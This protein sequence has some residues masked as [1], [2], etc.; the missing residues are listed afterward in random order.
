MNTAAKT[1]VAC[2][3]KAKS[4][5]VTREFNAPLADVWRAFTEKEILDQWWGPAPWRAETK[6][7]N[8]TVGGYWLYAMVGPASERHWG[9]MTFKAIEHLKH[10]DVE[11]SFC[12]EHGTL[13]QSLPV[14]NAR[15]AFIK[16]PF[17][18]RVELRTVYAT[19][20]DVQKIVD[21]GFEQGISVCLDQLSELLDNHKI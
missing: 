9:R 21:M 17:G 20:A 10:Y 8:F 14:S 15:H 12:D 4:I 3:I 1:L 16:T 7:M 13:N 18:T 2:D 5:F 11:D 6:S 19:E